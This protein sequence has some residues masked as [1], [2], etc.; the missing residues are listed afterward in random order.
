VKFDYRD[1]V[2]YGILISV[3]TL[4]ITL[5]TLHFVLI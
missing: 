2:R 3:P 5:V 4:I 1:F